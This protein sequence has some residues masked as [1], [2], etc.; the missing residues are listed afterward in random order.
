M[1]KG[2]HEVGA[3]GFSL[4]K[5]LIYLFLVLGA[6]ISLFPFYWMFIMAT[7]HNSAINSFPPKIIPGEYAWINFQ[8]VIDS[9]PFFSAIL[10]TLIVCTTVTIGVLFLSSLSGFAF[11]KLKFPFKNVLFALIL[12]TMMIPPQLGLVPTFYIITKLGWMNDLRAI[13]VPGLASAFGIFWMRQYIQDGVPD[14]LLDAAKIDGCSYFRVYWNIV[15]PII[16]PAFATLGIITFMAN[17]N[18]FLLPV[19]VLKQEKVQT[20]AIVI[21]NLAGDTR[22]LDYGKILSGTF[23]STLPL[24]IVFLAFNRLFISSLT[25]G[26]V[27][28]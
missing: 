8:S 26:A 27:K 19:T 17:W 10:N 23:W 1:K 16:L 28:N 24:V 15:V 3:K 20:I 9:T 22:S 2:H 6:L 21:R 4:S 14:E 12:I 5:L 7:H 13:I 11:A 25:Q 18:E